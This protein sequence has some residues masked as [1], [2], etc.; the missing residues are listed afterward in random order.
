MKIYLLVHELLYFV[1]KKLNYLSNFYI[2][3]TL[4]K[5]NRKKI[6]LNKQKLIHQLIDLV[7]LLQN[8]PVP[9]KGTSKSK[10]NSRKSQ[11]YKSAVAVAKK[12]LS[13]AKST[14]TGRSTSF[15][16]PKKVDENE[17]ENENED[18]T[19]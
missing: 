2:F 15:I 18:L 11:W 8:M 10:K 19:K 1:L 16:L 13:Q 4:P 6:M 9:K 3:F 14:L 12:V 17:N 5:K 7:H